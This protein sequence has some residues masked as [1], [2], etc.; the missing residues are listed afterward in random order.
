ME[1]NQYAYEARF[2]GTLFPPNM[3]MYNSP[4]VK[5][6]MFPNVSNLQSKLLKEVRAR[7]LDKFD[8]L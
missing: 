7:E 5:G 6:S 8:S 1:V 3:Q 4:L 2:K